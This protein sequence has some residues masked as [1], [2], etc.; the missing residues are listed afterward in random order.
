MKYMHSESFFMHADWIIFF[1]L[2]LGFAVF[3]IVGLYLTLKYVSQDFREQHN[4][5]NSYALATISVFSAVLLA[6]V[7]VVAWEKY[8]KAQEAASLEAQYLSDLLRGSIVIP[9]PLRSVI[10]KRGATYLDLVVQ[11]ELPAMGEEKIDL[12]PGWD[13]LVGIYFEM[14]KFKTDD[15]TAQVIFSDLFQ[16][17]NNLSDARRSRILLSHKHFPSILWSAICLSALFNI[18]FLFFFGMRSKKIHYAL[19]ILISIVIGCIFALIVSFDRPFQ[20]S[21]PISIDP[22][23]GITEN[24]ENYQERYGT[25]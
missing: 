19:T 20:R 7:A 23:T 11:K 17:L 25:K 22:F 9:E 1:L 15:Q 18:I 24:F 8:E 21:M 16:R 2:A 6:F 10:Q 12:T 4:E 13:E 5:L 3:G 14:S